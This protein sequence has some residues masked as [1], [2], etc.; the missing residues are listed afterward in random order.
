V[1]VRGADAVEPALAKALAAFW[2][3]ILY[4][5]ESRDWAFDQLRRL[6]PAERR[7][8]MDAAGREGLGGR[9]PD[10]RTLREILLGLLDAASAGL[11]RQGCCGESGEDERIWLTPLRERA[12]SGRSP[13][14]EALEAFRR[15]GGRALAAQLRCA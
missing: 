5:K 6:T 10:G 8:L 12:A 11:C 1:E 7:A 2:K 14:D 13:A 15:G 4:S 3:G 9:A